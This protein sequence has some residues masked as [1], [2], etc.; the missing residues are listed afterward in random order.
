MVVA[1]FFPSSRSGFL[2]VGGLSWHLGGWWWLLVVCIFKCLVMPNTWN[3]FYCKI[4]YFETNG[5]LIKTSILNSAC[6]ILWRKHWQTVLISVFQV[7]EMHCCFSCMF[8]YAFLN[9]VWCIFRSSRNKVLWVLKACNSWLEF[10]LYYHMYLPYLNLACIASTMRV[11]L[12]GIC[13]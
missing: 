9:T 3:C 2:V 5:A 7:A 13:L 11:F 12:L 4:F 8:S 10:T 6:K 1:G